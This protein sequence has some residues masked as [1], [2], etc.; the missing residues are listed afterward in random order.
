[1]KNDI[2]S[3]K[4]ATLQTTFSQGIF[5]IGPKLA[6]Y[7][8]FE[9]R[10]FDLGHPV[11]TVEEVEVEVEVT[12]SKVKYDGNIRD[13]LEDRNIESNHFRTLTTALRKPRG[14]LDEPKMNPK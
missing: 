2:L 6:E 1:M 13:R 14:N 4:T 5:E 8:L 9:I 12:I 7:L 10:N 11:A 3:Q